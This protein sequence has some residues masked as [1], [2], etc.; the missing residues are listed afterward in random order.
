ML[1][2]LTWDQ[3]GPLGESGW[4]SVGKDGESDVKSWHLQGCSP[5]LCRLRTDG[6]VPTS[7]Y[8]KYWSHA[9]VIGPV[10]LVAAINMCLTFLHCFIDCYRREIGYGPVD[11]SAVML[12]IG[13]GSLFLEGSCSTLLM[14]MQ[15]VVIRRL[16]EICMVESYTR[17]ELREMCVACWSGFSYRVYI[18][19][20][21]RDSR[22]WIIV[23]LVIA[24]L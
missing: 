5:R 15:K 23:Y 6:F 1:E 4:P 22:I 16:R 3:A 13:T 19:S 2:W 14:T 18:D 10:N 11:R 21:H 20:N 24:S 7:K 8:W 17:T 12:W 9:G